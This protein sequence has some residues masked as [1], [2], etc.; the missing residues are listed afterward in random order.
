[1]QLVREEPLPV[2]GQGELLA[3]AP[4][5]RPFWRSP[6]F[7]LLAA[8]SI[9]GVIALVRARGVEGPIAEVPGH[10]SLHGT[11]APAAVPAATA[12]HAASVPGH[13]A[14][15]RVQ[16]VFVAPSAR[17]VAVVGDFND[18]DP[19]ATPLALAGGVWSR[20][21]DV[22]VGRHDYAFVI[23]GKRWVA[24][25][26]APRAPA[27]EFGNGYSVIVVGGEQ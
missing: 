22:P 5:R 2:R 19:A 16:F 6:A 4:H 21:L 26:T 14:V 15:A 11:S 3:I 20:E 27:D 25:P 24:D 8:A 7:G 23:D 12:A 10:P 1:M 9:A 17:Q 18:W 13:V